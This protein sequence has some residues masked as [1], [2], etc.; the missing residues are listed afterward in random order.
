METIATC[1][2]KYEFIGLLGWF[3]KNCELP[4]GVECLHPRCKKHN[5]ELHSLS[6][7]DVNNENTFENVVSR[8]T[9]DIYILHL[10]HDGVITGKDS[11]IHEVLSHS[12]LKIVQY[13]AYYT[14]DNVWNIFKGKDYTQYKHITFVPIE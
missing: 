12:G 8:M 2:H 11:D 7:P 13:C 9:D 4:Y 14:A 5:C 1:N 6:F 3:C 10:G